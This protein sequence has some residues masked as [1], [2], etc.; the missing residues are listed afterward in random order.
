MIKKYFALFFVLI[1]SIGYVSA[2]NLTVR[3]ENADIG[4][5]HLMVGVFNS[6]SD[7][8]NKTFRDQRIT[9]TERTMEII[10]P[11]LPTGRYAVSVYQDSNDNGKLDTLLFGIPK[12]KYGFSNDVRLPNYEKCIFDF[13]GNMTITIQIK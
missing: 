8:P 10:F 4:K 13:N 12:E 11:N 3:I 2:Q 7:F 5:G 1:V 6:E 9:I